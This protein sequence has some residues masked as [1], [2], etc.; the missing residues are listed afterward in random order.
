MKVL[1]RVLTLIALCVP[2][3]V[4]QEPDVRAGSLQMTRVELE[5][6]AARLEQEASSSAYSER[7]RERA[8]RQ[9]ELIRERLRA[10]DFRVGDRVILQVEGE[11]E[12]SDTI[13]VDP[14][15][16]IVLPVIGSISL[17]GVLR[18][19]L[20]DYLTEE[21]AR[22]IRDPIVNARSLI[23]L[24]VLG[25]IGQPGFYVLPADMLVG[26]A[27]MAAGGPAPDSK[28]EDLEIRRGSRTI[29]EGEN[30]QEQIAEGATLDQLNLR[31]GDEIYM[32][33]EASQ[34]RWW[35]VGRYVL[36]PLVS[37]V[38]GVRIF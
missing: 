1:F 10:G 17:E 9:V 15:P 25:Q 29:W 11:E 3:V 16:Q 2:A 34:N 26:E 33:R 8:R 19:E 5:E 27:L 35:T 4:A 30:L 28:V 31:A 7:L 38:L 23:R 20:E 32:P 12:L 37:L 13:P 6:L 18:A 36:I 21:L 22:Y 14:G 24:S